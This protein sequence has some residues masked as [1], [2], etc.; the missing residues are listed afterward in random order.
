MSTVSEPIA[1]SKAWRSPS[2]SRPSFEILV[3]YVDSTIDDVNV[4]C[5]SE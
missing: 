1:L 4:N 5:G 3:G 2:P